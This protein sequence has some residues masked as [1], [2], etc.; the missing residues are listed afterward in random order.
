MRGQEQAVRKDGRR[1][2]EEGGRGWMGGESKV[3]K[4][5]DLYVFVY[6]CVI[7]DRRHR[8][9]WTMDHAWP[10]LGGRKEERPPTVV[11][12]FCPLGHPTSAN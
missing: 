10:W 3:G 11:S 1:D 12:P 8:R 2:R 6:L 9:P 5:R 7:F 4:E